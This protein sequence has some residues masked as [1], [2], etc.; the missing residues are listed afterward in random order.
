MEPKFSIILTERFKTVYVD[1]M[2]K[3]ITSDESIL[4][5]FL[6]GVEGLPQLT[7]LFPEG[8]QGSQLKKKH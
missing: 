3:G 1:R 5:V 8:D 6:P 7:W 2:A 4:D